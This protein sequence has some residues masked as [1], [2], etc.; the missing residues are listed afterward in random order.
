DALG[1]V[2]NIITRAPETGWGGQVE[3]QVGANDQ[4]DA[5]RAALS[6]N[7]NAGSER[8]RLSVHASHVER[9]PYAEFESAPVT[10][11]NAGVKVPPSTHPNPGVR[12][13]QDSYGVDVQY[14]DE[15]RVDTLGARLE[16]LAT[17]ALRLALDV[18]LMREEREASYLSSQY[19]T[20]YLA[21][22][23]PLGASNI[24]ARQFDDNQRLDAAA[25]LSW[26][27]FETL[28][29]RYRLHYSRYDK[30]REVRAIPYADLG[31]TSAQAS[32]SAT[33]D[34][35][36]TQWVNDL[37]ATWRPAPGHTLV[38]G[39]EH[40]DNRIDSE[41]LKAEARIF[42]SVFLQHE[43][44]LLP[45]LNLVYGA[46]YDD[47]SVGGSRTSLQLGGVWTFSPLARLRAN[48]A[49]GFKA[50]DD[51]SLYVDQVNPQGIAML[52]AEIVAPERGKNEAHALD[53]ESSDTLELGLAGGG[54][55]WDYGITVFRTE[56]EDRIELVR[57][58]SN[59]LSYNTFRNIGEAR[60]Q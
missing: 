34:S 11:P 42:E 56:V 23:K 59:G 14:R 19:P 20:A 21:K 49:Q 7:L 22:G 8:L 46:R 33:N 9:D 28:D 25:T 3:T 38:G 41:A 17:P 40:R 10:V 12:Q 43:W 51:R 15:A 54:S 4:G 53:P 48:F 57:E 13:I 52:G 45:A 31:Y 24:P 5:G 18:D 35:A 32:A 60:I 27:P 47:D 6:A 39:I 29:L 2:I 1:G 44:Q 58:I 36:L 30:D 26:S 50:P 16:W 55:Q 37:T